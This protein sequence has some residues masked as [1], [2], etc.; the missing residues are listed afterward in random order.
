MTAQKRFSVIAPRLTAM[1]REAGFE[2]RGQ[3]VRREEGDIIGV[4]AIDRDRKHDEQGQIQFGMT[5]DICHMRY[6]HV[7]RR[8]PFPGDEVGA[9]LLNKDTGSIRGKPEERFPWNVGDRTDVEQIVE[10][11]GAILREVAIPTVSKLL[12]EKK[13]TD[14]LR[15]LVERDLALLHHR[16][17]LCMLL[18]EEGNSDE[19]AILLEDTIRRFPDN[20]H[21]INRTLNRLGIGI[22]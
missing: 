8:D 22:T 10:N 2:V 6:H 9:G 7:I 11:A 14:Y 15:S 17:C 16:M 3:T 20:F 18:K 1:A 12:S 13:L 19:L 5:M 21:V 4:I